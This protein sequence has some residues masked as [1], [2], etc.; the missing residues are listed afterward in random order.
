MCVREAAVAGRFYPSDADDLRRTV[1]GLL[2]EARTS[3]PP[4][5]GAPPRAMI[6]PHA[7]LSYSG[8][9]AAS[10]YCQLEPWAG[11]LTHVLLLGPCHRVPFE[12]LALSSAEAFATPLG[13]VALDRLAAE[14]SLQVAGV[15]VHDRAHRDEHS[16]EVQLPFLQLV[17]PQASLLPV[18]AG[19]TT[20]AATAELIGRFLDRPGWVT[21][22]SSDL[23]HFHAP[24]ACQRID[25][26]TSRAIEQLADDRL[27]GKRA[28]GHLGIRGLL[29]AVRE[30]QGR[31]LT[32]DLRHS[33]DTS[34]FRDSVVGYGAYVVC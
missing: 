13:Q 28:C 10:A 6:V 17:L 11:E 14:E 9:I 3:K 24:E 29:Q 19:R 12:G 8:P 16:L 20:P 15:Q 25:A 30:R 26:E 5:A 2:L 1:E 21:I 4:S 34:G 31:V 27:D 32:V 23:S 18:L 22:V 33:G 7:G